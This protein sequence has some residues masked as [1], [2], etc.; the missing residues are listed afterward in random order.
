MRVLWFA[1]A[2]ATGVALWELVPR[3]AAFLLSLEETP[4][5]RG[6]RVAARLGCFACHG[7][8]GRGGVPNPGSEEGEV[9]SFHEGTPMM[10]VANDEEIREYILDGAPARKRARPSYRKQLNAQALRMPA[11]RGWIDD[12]DVDALV[13]YV[14]AVSGLLQPQEGELARAERLA[15]EMGCFACHGEMG[16]GG[17]PNPG[18]LKGYIPAF[19]GDDFREL[20]RDDDELREWI[21]TGS[22]RRIREHPI[23]GYFF[24]RQRIRMPAYEKFLSSGDIELLVRYVN[25][26][27]SGQWRDRPAVR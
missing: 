14:R 9:P 24:R 22:L 16:T 11:Y 18:S 27:A 2:M 20:V 4:A 8:D 25:W 10:Y 15:G 5:A 23:G 21:R 17:V 7:P 19:T 6:R 12:E 26:L 13:A 3:A 1:A